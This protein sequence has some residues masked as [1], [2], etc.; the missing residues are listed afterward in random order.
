[1]I[2][3][4]VRGTK[5]YLP[6]LIG[7]VAFLLLLVCANVANMLFGRAMERRKEIAVRLALGA[8]RLRL[9][10]QMLTE[11]MMLAF[12]GGAIGLLLSFWAVHLFKVAVPEE[13]T[14]F[15]PG[16]DR[17]GIN[18]TALLFNLLITM[19]TGLLFGLAPAWQSSRPNLNEALKDGSK[20]SSSAG[21]RGRM[22]GALVIVEVALSLVLLIGA[23]LMVRSFTA[24]LRDDFGFRPEKALSFDLMYRGD[25]SNVRSFYGRLIERLE[26]L[27][28]V[29]A[30]GA[31]NALPMGGNENAL[32][33]VAGPT[34]SGKIERLVDFRVVTPG[35]F[36]AIGMRLL[37]GR[38]FTVADNEHAPGVLIINEALARQF[39]PDQDVIGKRFGLAESIIVGI[40]GD[41]RD[42]SLDKAAAPG[43]YAPFAQ[44]PRV[45]MGI[46]LRSTVESEALIGS[47]RKMMKELYPA[48]PILGFKTMEQRIYERTAAKRIM[49]VTMGLFAGIALL[50]AG[51]G[52]YAV[53]TYAVSRR[54]H[55]IG[56][57]LALGAQRRDV[58]GLILRHGLRLTLS[59]VAI[60]LIAAWAATRL[61]IN[62]L[63]GVSATDPP[64][65]AGISLLLIG[66]ALLACYIPARRATKVDPL[67]ALRTE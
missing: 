34:P 27:P 52:L 15:I 50:L 10:G 39:F 40:V 8:S 48:Q 18:R 22:R 28:G 56:V 45:E 54:A 13:L 31:S 42:D 61:L 3:D 64:T 33:G 6:P 23:G 17:L 16:F 37:R 2:G 44:T 14:Q 43:F 57:R 12:A 24:M 51:M 21:L 32:I 5:N 49:T 26:T 20:G 29:T 46:V 38:D 25:E 7:T 35:Y 53:M 41:A 19:L 9:V 60:G 11:S 65:F 47:I 58:L 66:V 63:Y 67:V 36:K 59:G 4:Y 55:E 1:M 30:A 62:L